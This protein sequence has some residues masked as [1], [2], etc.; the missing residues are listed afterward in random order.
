MGEVPVAVDT[1]GA[2]STATLTSVE[3]SGREAGGLVADVLAT[4]D[5]TADELDPELAPELAFAGAWHL[6][7]P[8]RSREVLASLRYGFEALRD[9]MDDADLTT[10]Q[11]VWREDD[12]TFHSRNPFPVGGVVEDPATGAAAAALGGYLRRRSLVTTPADVVVLQGF[13][14]GS[15]S[16]I[17]VHIPDAGG[18]DVSGTAV[19]IEA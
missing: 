19:R 17:E 6:V 10:I 7:L 2:H 14:M 3:P 18:I 5:W 4:T 8:V 9:V 1:D 16:R 12:A 13:D 15:P 11:V